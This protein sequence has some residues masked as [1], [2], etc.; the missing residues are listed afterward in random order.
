[1]APSLPQVLVVGYECSCERSLK[2]SCGAKS[3]A[4]FLGGAHR[5]AASPVL[6][7]F[8]NSSASS[9]VIREKDRAQP[10]QGCSH[11]KLSV[12]SA[13]HNFDFL[14]DFVLFIGAKN[15]AEPYKSEPAEICLNKLAGC[16][17]LNAPL[18]TTPLATKGCEE[19]TSGHRLRLVTAF[20]LIR[21]SAFL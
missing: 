16:R 13:R 15:G 11:P 20:H 18:A 2:E 10:F 6:P 3:N 14:P 17:N 1:V 7:S 9:Y 21:T 12:D 8:Q 5:H 19:W 4:F